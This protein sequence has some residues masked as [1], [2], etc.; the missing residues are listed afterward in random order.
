MFH[1]NLFHLKVIAETIVCIVPGSKPLFSALTVF[2]LPAIKVGAGIQ[3]LL[4]FSIGLHLQS[5]VALL[6]SFDYLNYCIYSPISNV[7]KDTS[8]VMIVP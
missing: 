3:V 6:V 8:S 1:H 7:Y 2:S 4:F 5:L